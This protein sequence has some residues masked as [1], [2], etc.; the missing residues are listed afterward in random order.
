[1]GDDLYTDET[2]WKIAPEA[3][4]QRECTQDTRIEEGWCLVESENPCVLSVFALEQVFQRHLPE[5]KDQVSLV[6]AVVARLLLTHL[7][8]SVL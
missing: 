8:I 7:T 2:Y 3:M 4:L 1:M 5:G 6:L